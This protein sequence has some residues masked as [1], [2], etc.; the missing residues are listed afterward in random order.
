MYSKCTWYTES[1]FLGGRKKKIPRKK[2]ENQLFDIKQNGSM[3]IFWKCAS[4]SSLEGSFQ[5]PF[6]KSRFWVRKLKKY[7][8]KLQKKL[9][10]IDLKWL[11]PY[12]AN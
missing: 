8:L 11:P 10:I 7:A 3:A 12:F 2:T 6:L 1:D 5:T 4:F 9:F